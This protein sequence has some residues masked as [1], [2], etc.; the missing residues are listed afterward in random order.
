MSPDADLTTRWAEGWTVSRGT[1]PPLP[2][3]WGLRIEVG[4]P[5]QLRRHVLLDPDP[6]AA[7]SELAASVGEPLTWIKAAVAPEALRPALGADWSQD[8]PGW[9]MAWDV[10]P[11]AVR[12]PEGYT[13]ATEF[14][15]AV[16]RV[17]VLAADG[18]LAARAQ[19]GHGDGFGVV[20]QVR[21]EAEH[22][23][24]GLGSLVMGTLANVAHEDGA[25]TSILGASVEGRA[26]YEA[27]G[28]KVCAP[29]AGFIF[30]RGAGE[31][32]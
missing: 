18:S 32:C 11:A 24:R 4:A 26:L 15:E 28:W 5:N 22:Q 30:R 23:R 7:A 19:Y 27:L 9:L 16:T 3:R 13:V 21:T 14:A 10:A 31:A 2:T 8:D 25:R 6:A 1:P 29:L 17:R 20:D 12:V